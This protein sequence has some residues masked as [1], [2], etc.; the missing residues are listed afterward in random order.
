M[1]KMP[2]SWHQENLSNVCTY[3]A[4]KKQELALLQGECNRLERN[5]AI[6]S[7]QIERAIA[8]GKDGFD[9]E[10]YCRPRKRET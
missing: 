8:E 5:I 7:H 6:L 10:R 2:I 4:H 9:A 3:L 1:A